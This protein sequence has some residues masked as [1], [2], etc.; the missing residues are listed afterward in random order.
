MPLS[1]L[2]VRPA[3]ACPEDPLCR[4]LVLCR[5]ACRPEGF[6]LVERVFLARPA[7]CGFGDAIYAWHSAARLLMGHGLSCNGRRWNFGTRRQ[8]TRAGRRNR[9]S[10]RVGSHRA[11][12][13]HL[14]T[15][16]ARL[17]QPSCRASTPGG[18]SAKAS[19]PYG[20]INALRTP[21][22]CLFKNHASLMRGSRWIPEALY[23]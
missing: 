4:A 7:V 10:I 3:C 22:S 1:L 19:I 18:G 2:L 17:S 23:K 11:T 8:R 12:R 21:C 16:L 20:P 5:G 15:V 9:V 13:A 14:G 6:L